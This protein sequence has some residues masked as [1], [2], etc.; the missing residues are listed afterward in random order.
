M[1]SG[2]R[3]S[4]QKPRNGDVMASMIGASVLTSFDTLPSRISTCMP[5]RSF[6][7]ASS[8]PVVS[9]QFLMPHDR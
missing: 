9:W 7:R 6:S 2:L 4:V 5:F 1:S 8:T 3:S